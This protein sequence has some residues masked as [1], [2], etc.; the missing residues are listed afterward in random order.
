MESVV[1]KTF[2]DVDG[3]DVG[4]LLERSDVY[5]EL[6]GNQ[7]LD[8]NNLLLLDVFLSLIFFFKSTAKTKNFKNWLI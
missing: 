2:S 4:R 5:N 1:H 6:V 7:T 8:S 3:F